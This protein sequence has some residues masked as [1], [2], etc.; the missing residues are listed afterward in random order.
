MTD[1]MVQIT[2]EIFDILAIATKEMKN[3]RTSEFD[4][5]F[6]SHEA[7]IVSEKFLTRVVRAVRRKDGMK[8]IDK[9]I[10]EVAVMAIAQP[11]KVTHNI[12]SG[13]YHLFSESSASFLILLIKQT[14]DGVENMCS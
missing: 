11:L 2:V 1:K 8:K 5:R 4:L 6:R 10:S 12:D 13:R 9:L 14:A 3:G 7:D